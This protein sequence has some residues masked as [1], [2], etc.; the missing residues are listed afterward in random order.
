MRQ[1]RRTRRTNKNRFNKW[2]LVPLITMVFG[3]SFGLVLCITQSKTGHN[4]AIEQQD[5]RL[6][7]LLTE[8]YQR[9][10]KGTEGFYVVREIE[11][12]IDERVKELEDKL[13]TMSMTSNMG[14]WEIQ[15]ITLGVKNT[16]DEAEDS[17]EMAGCING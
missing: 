9:C 4:I 14:L 5:M 16:V 1:R 2:H 6:N 11:R 10:P 12:R 3:L 8:A 17:L 7:E 15:P 13:K